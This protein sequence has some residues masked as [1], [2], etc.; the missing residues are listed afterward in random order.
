MANVWL[1]GYDPSDPRDLIVPMARIFIVPQDPRAALKNLISDLPYQMGGR[2]VKPDAP[3]VIRMTDG[4]T[5]IL[6]GFGVTEA[7]ELQDM[8]YQQLEKK[9][10]DWRE[11]YGFADRATFDSRLREH[12]DWRSKNPNEHPTPMNGLEREA[13]RRAIPNG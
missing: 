8:A 2:A 1:P 6:P 9:R 12:M 7:A 4:S 3:I 10:E 5:T 13:R 11:K